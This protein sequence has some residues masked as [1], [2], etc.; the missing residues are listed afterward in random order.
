MESPNMYKETSIGKEI[1]KLRIEKGWC[2]ADM[3]EKLSISIPAVSKIETGITI[4]NI[5]R[6]KQIA[7]ILGFSVDYFLFADENYVSTQGEHEIERLLIE[8]DKKN[9]LIIKLQ[10]LTIELYE[11]IRSK[12]KSK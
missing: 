9:Y 7:K 5:T 3:A 6:L 1:R 4:I 2:Q 10:E 8:L 11:Q 12:P